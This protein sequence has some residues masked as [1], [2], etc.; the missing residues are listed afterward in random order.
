MALPPIGS[1]AL[2]TVMGMGMA[3]PFLLLTICPPLLRLLPK[4]GAWMVV[5]KQLMGFMLMASVLWLV[6][7]WEAQTDFMSV[8]LMLGA[9]FILSIGA[10]FYG[11][12][13]PAD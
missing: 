13:G 2:F 12:C 4:P 11:N 3:L 7:V 5:L 10:W 1:F 8:M 9:L 6:W